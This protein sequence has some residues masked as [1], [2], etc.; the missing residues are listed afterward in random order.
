MSSSTQLK[1]KQRANNINITSGNIDYP[2]EYIVYDITSNVSANTMLQ[3]KTIE[4]LVTKMETNET[5]KIDT[6]SDIPKAYKREKLCFK[7][8][9]DKYIP[10]KTGQ[11]YI[12]IMTAENDPNASPI[13]IASFH[14]IY[15]SALKLK[16]DEFGDLIMLVSAEHRKQKKSTKEDEKTN[17]ELF[18]RQQFVV[19]ESL[20]RTH[21]QISNSKT[22]S[23]PTLE[24]LSKKNKSSGKAFAPPLMSPIRGN[25]DTSQK[26]VT[27]SDSVEVQE[28][29]SSYTASQVSESILMTDES[30]SIG[31]L[32]PEQQTIGTQVPGTQMSEDLSMKLYNNYNG[33]TQQIEYEP[34]S[35]VN[36]DVRTPQKQNTSM[37][38]SSPSSPPSPPLTRA[39]LP[40]TTPRTEPLKITCIPPLRRTE[41]YEQMLGDL[42]DE[43]IKKIIYNMVKPGKKP[44]HENHVLM[45]L[46]FNRI[47]LLSID[48]F[49]D[50][51]V[52][53]LK[54]INS[55]HEINTSFNG[56]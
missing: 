3:S 25:R 11:I 17:V 18:E 40:P 44:I 46:I 30:I 56:K 41:L 21:S 23:T 1:M 53:S 5:R 16:N 42:D 24:S 2:T 32:T 26:N 47:S 37:L 48:Q 27:I 22:T 29:P 12:T 45:T 14:N 55:K 15:D 50:E 35:Y 10:S 34:F 6:M 20:K 7:I 9:I 51:M 54:N 49:V 43:M 8:S 19:P 28:P 39:V 38:S 52:E 33:K 36:E 4:N 31:D 13:Y